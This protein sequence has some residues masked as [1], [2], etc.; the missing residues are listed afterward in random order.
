MCSSWTHLQ[1]QLCDVDSMWATY[2]VYGGLHALVRSQRCHSG[3]WLWPRWYS[4]DFKRD[5][6][7]KISG[8]TK[9]SLYL[10]PAGWLAL[11]LSANTPWREGYV[12]LLCRRDISWEF[13]AL[14]HN[15]TVISVISVG[16]KYRFPWFCTD[17][18]LCLFYRPLYTD[19]LN[20]CE[21]KSV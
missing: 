15:I 13:S 1:K 7:V 10:M 6:G 17:S 12:L 18:T 3:D 9:S 2:K 21:H 14:W 5:D 19:I 4:G 20:S 8:A 16:G 11:K